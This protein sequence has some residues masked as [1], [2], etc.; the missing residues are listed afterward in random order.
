MQAARGAFAAGFDS[1]YARPGRV[2]PWHR[3]TS[4]GNDLLR[5]VAGSVHG[6][7]IRHLSEAPH[8][9][10]GVVRSETGRGALGSRSSR[11]NS[12]SHPLAGIEE[13]L[14]RANENI[15]NLDVEI[16]RFLD[17]KGHR[18]TLERDPKRIEEF[19]EFWSKQAVPARFAALISEVLHGYRSSLDNLIWEL[20]REAGH[21]PK[22]P[23]VIEFPILNTRPTTPDKLAMFTR[24]IDG[25]GDRAKAVIESLQPY[26]AVSPY[27]SP[28]KPLLVLHDMNRFDKHR[29]L[30]VV[31]SRS[32]QTPQ[33]FLVQLVGIRKDPATG[34]E[35]QTPL[36]YREVFTGMKLTAL[37]AFRQFGDNG[38]P[39]VGVIP[40][41]RRIEAAV[42]EAIKRFDPFFPAR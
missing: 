18:E 27:Q 1:G 22:N 8:F 7:E 15:Q 6:V 11:D 38:P 39:N 2:W 16:N 24:K 13:R 41:L 19:R 28:H 37:V 36:A 5:G 32:Q 26:N 10:L 31:G 30:T 40:G 35:T 12:M 23:N 17:Q 29:E 3:R 9:L 21:R 42:S 33:L 4:G 14:K 20:L 34:R 25:V